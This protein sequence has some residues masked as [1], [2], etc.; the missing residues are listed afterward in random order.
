MAVGTEAEPPHGPV[1]GK[2]LTDPLA[3]RGVPQYDV[4][5]D[6]SRGQHGA[7]RAEREAGDHRTLADKIAQTLAGLRVPQGDRAV[8]ESGRECRSIRAVG[9]AED[10]PRTR[11]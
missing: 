3:C 10:V 11:V 8:D 7:V 4:A 5:V 2:R 6:A 9:Q 1:P